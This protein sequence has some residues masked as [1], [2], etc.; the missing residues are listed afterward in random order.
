MAD[1]ASDEAS[2][3]RSRRPPRWH[4]AA[5]I[6]KLVVTGLDDWRSCRGPLREV[7]GFRVFSDREVG[8]KVWVDGENLVVNLL[9]RSLEGARLLA[10]END[11]IPVHRHN[12]AAF[13]RRAANFVPLGGLFL[14]V[15]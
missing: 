15:S 8:I 2:L 3:G 6:T 12:L 4:V 14:R 13:Q 5:I 9:D 7:L 1:T 11:K 10:G